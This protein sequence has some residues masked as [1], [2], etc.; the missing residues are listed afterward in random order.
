MT[1]ANDSTWGWAL[2]PEGRMVHVNDVERGRNCNC[3][4]H[5]CGAALISRQGEINAWHFAHAKDEDCSGTAES[6]LHF[7]AKEILCALNGRIHLPEEVI[8]KKDWPDPESMNCVRSEFREKLDE[9]MTHIEPAKIISSDLTVRLEPKEWVTNYGFQPDA[10]IEKNEKQILVEF[11]V[12]HEVDQEKRNKIKKT[13]IGSIEIDL[14]KECRNIDYSELEKLIISDAPRKWITTCRPKKWEEKENEFNNKLNRQAFLLNKM[15]IQEY[16]IRGGVIN[17]CPRMDE[18]GFAPV[19]YSKCEKCNHHGGAIRELHDTPLYDLLSERIRCEE[20][21]ILCSHEYV[22]NTRPT[23]RQ[24]NRVNHLAYCD[25]EREGGLQSHL[26]DQWEQNRIFCGK[27]IGEHP[28]CPKCG[29][30]LVLRRNWK[31]RS[32]FWGCKDYQY[33]CRGSKNYNPS[34]TPVIS[35][36]LALLDK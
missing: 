30:I 14:S 2:N 35:E 36:I 12:T 26:P 33:R 13:K 22:R 32:F 24:I 21:G 4:C 10:V 1:E 15:K 23:Q 25:L 31:N 5:E 16:I 7:A 6:A 27:F 29:E 19:T 9:T 11:L 8:R 18:P 34:N 3:T 20:S 17:A 28:P